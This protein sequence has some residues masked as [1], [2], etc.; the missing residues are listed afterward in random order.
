MGEDLLSMKL[1]K[2]F[3][4]CRRSHNTSCIKRIYKRVEGT[5]KNLRSVSVVGDN[6]RYILGEDILLLTL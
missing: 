3:S 5:E 6:V 2:T 4:Q 1:F